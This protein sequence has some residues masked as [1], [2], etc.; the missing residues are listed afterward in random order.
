LAAFAPE[1]PTILLPG[2][3]FLLVLGKAGVNRLKRQHT[4]DVVSP[5]QG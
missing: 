2:L 5:R 1:L 3:T 4:A